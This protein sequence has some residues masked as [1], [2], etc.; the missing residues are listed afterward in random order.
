MNSPKKIISKT[1][2]IKSK[3]KLHEISYYYYYEII[4]IIK[5]INSIIIYC[6][7]Y[8]EIPPWFVCHLSSVVGQNNHDFVAGRIV[9]PNFCP[10]RFT[11]TKTRFSTSVVVCDPPVFVEKKEYNQLLIVFVKT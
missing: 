2:K 4:I 9:C 5:S 6:Y 8:Y 1:K 10:H 11:S 3:M 7:C